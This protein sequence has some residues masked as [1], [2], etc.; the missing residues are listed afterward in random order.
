M[1][2]YTQKNVCSLCSILH[3]TMCNTE[4]MIYFIH[5]SSLYLYFPIVTHF[6]KYISLLSY[7]GSYD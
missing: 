7:F 4:Y 5:I 1:R 6:V 2:S 3:T